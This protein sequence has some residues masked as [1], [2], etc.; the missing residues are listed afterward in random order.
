MSLMQS[1]L[2][3]VTFTSAII[4]G[5]TGC[6]LFSNEGYEGGDHRG[7]GPTGP[8]TGTEMA[9]KIAPEDIKAEQDEN[10]PYVGGDHR[11]GGPTGP[12]SNQEIESVAPEVIDAEVPAAEEASQESELPAKSSTEEVYLGGDHRGGGPSSLLE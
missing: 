11:G 1:G 12:L 4:M 10:A 2:K 5:V 6:A 7:G 9:Q 8:L 3:M